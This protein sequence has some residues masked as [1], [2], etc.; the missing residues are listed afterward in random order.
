VSSLRVALR[1]ARRDAWR[2][3]G[4]SSLVVAMIALPVLG[5]TATDVLYRSF[6]LSPDQSATRRMG[7]ADAILSDSGQQTVRQFP[8]ID[9]I[10]WDGVVEDGGQARTGS[11]PSYRSMVPAG[12]RLLLESSDYSPSS[13][14]SAGGSTVSV[15]VTA[16]DVDDPLTEGL[17]VDQ[18]GRAARDA[19]EVVVTGGLLR[20]LG[21]HLG[22]QVQ[23]KTSLGTQTRTVVG[24][25]E[26]PSALDERSVLLP[27]GSFPRPSRALVDVPGE[28]T[29]SDVQR[30]NAQGFLLQPRGHVPGEPP[31]PP[32]VQEAIAAATLTAIT[33]VV[34]MALLEVVLL[35]GPAFAVGAKRRTRELALLTAS[36]G[37]RRDL[38]RTVLGGG[39][40]IGVAGGLVGVAGGLLLTRLALHTL[41]RVNGSLVGSFDIRPLELLLIAVVGVLTAVVAAIIPA[42]VA[43]RQDV[44][45]GLTGRR[46][47]VR[48]LK[49]VPVLGVLAA[50]AGALIAVEG[51][52]RRNVNLI[53]AGSAMAELGLVATTPFLVG[54]AGRLARFLPLGPRLAL[55][56]AARNRGRTAPAVSAILAAVA[57]SIAISMVVASF[58]KRDRDAYSP[59]APTG[60]TWLM[61]DGEREAKT[62]QVL[63]ALHRYLPHATTQL[64]RGVG[65]SPDVMAVPTGTLSWYADLE[66]VGGCDGPA[67]AAGS[68]ESAV[69]S[70]G[71]TGGG[72]F[73]GALVVGDAATVKALTGL[74]DASLDAVRAVLA[75]GGAVVPS[76]ALRPDGTAVIRVH[77]PSDGG[78]D[79]TRPVVVPAVTTPDVG[80]QPAVLSAAAATRAGLAIHQLGVVATSS[81]PPTA[82]E[83]DRLRGALRT[84]DLDGWVFVERGYQS[85][86]GMGLL[87][88]MLGSA[89]IVLGASGIATGLAA[90]DGRADLATL[91]AVGA[92]PRTRRSLAAAQSAAT[93]GLGTLLGAVAGLV[94]AVAILRALTRT[95]GFEDGHVVKQQVLPLVFPWSSFAVTLLVVP[96]LAALAAAALTRSRLPMVRRLG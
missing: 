71:T 57:G 81:T 7:T 31:V 69:C 29:W 6:Q 24:S 1:L 76:E 85:E 80:F 11:V 13:T 92:S 82:E 20:R 40:V 84:L 41:E 70:I 26:V 18:H 78:P 12:S 17:Y 58:D 37:E 19:H 77:V 39:V 75:R 21:L 36:G 86:Y 10:A 65:L 38:R 56:D 91:A 66:V 72:P 55:R 3:K 67:A 49:R 43:A 16:T 45:A 42:R 63:D 83:E 14:V 74:D 89:V 93:A 50:G 4:R 62:S 46:G 2:S 90:A 96:V 64:V 8:T 61:L 30:A 51:A 9:G 53:L 88:L 52:R 44:V 73:G 27:V 25:V 15:G 23:V 95:V 35:A 48:S 33:L 68:G 60:T 34:G 94:P 5:V 28:L 79:R 54:Q 87:A 47:S 32:Q 22:Q 59:Q